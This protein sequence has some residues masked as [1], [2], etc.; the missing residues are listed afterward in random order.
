MDGGAG[1]SKS[2]TT[3]CEAGPPW[4]RIVLSETPMLKDLSMADLDYVCEL[5]ARTMRAYVETDLGVWD[6]AVAR[7][8]MVLLLDAGEFSGIFTGSERVGAVAVKRVADR[9][10]LEQL[11]IEPRFQGRGVGTRVVQ[12]LKCDATRAQVPLR[13]RVFFSNPARKLYERLGFTVVKR[14]NKQYHMEY[15]A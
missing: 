12:E 6:A 5:A 1:L 8:K 14:Q 7:E 9:M 4:L 13:L 15:L 2:P 10:Q 3:L 11:F